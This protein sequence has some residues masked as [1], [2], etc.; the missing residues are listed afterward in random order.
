MKNDTNRPAS[1]VGSII[2]GET[3]K[4]IHS[5]NT[6]WECPRCHRIYSPTTKTCE[7]CNPVARNNMES[8]KPY[9]GVS[10]LPQQLNE[11]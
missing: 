1:V 3:F 4:A 6:G 10:N 7:L 11:G 2:F 9:V 5:P 8:S